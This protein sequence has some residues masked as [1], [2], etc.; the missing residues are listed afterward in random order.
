[1]LLRRP[2]DKYIVLIQVEEA[3]PTT[4]YNLQLFLQSTGAPVTLGNLFGKIKSTNME[5]FKVIL[6]VF[7]YCSKNLETM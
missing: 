1:M 5:V 3:P 4:I 7:G 2:K 6:V